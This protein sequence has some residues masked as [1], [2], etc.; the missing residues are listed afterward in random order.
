MSVCPVPSRSISTT[1]FDSLV[2]RSTR[3]TR[4]HAYSVSSTSTSLAT[5]QERVVLLRGADGD[6][7]PVRDPDVPDQHAAVQERL[8]RPRGVG[9]PAEQ[10]EVRVAGHHVVARRRQRGDH[11]LPLGPQQC[12]RPERRVG[13]PQRGPRRSLGQRRQVVRQPNELQR[14]DDG[15][16]RG[17]VAEP[18]AGEGERLAHRAGDDELAPVR[19]Q[20]DGARWAGPRTRRT[21]RRRRR[22][23]GAASTSAASSSGS[24]DCPVGLFGL[25]RN[26]TSG[27]RSASRRG[28]GRDVDGEVGPARGG[29]PVGA[30]AAGDERVH[31]VRRLEADRDPARA[32]EGLQQLLEDLVG[33]VGRPQVRAGERHAGGPVR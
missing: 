6:P 20:Q 10:H 23:P 9:E 5:S 27:A 18:A 26:I 4:A 16:G 19:G 25:V 22:C 8:P 2:T 30:G 3:P 15:R 11:P 1:T 12:H 14:V 13:V 24:S 33:A 17:E 7:Q 29:Q 32:A 28:R 31:R 21:P